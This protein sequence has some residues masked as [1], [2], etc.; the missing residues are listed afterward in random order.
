MEKISRLIVK[1]R[2]VI[3]AVSLALLFPSLLGYLGTRVNYDILTYLPGEIETMQGQDIL[4]DQFGTG[5]FSLY[6][7]EGMEE[8]DIVTLR[9]NIEKVDHVKKVLSYDSLMDIS[10]PMEML[11]DD[12]VSAFHNGDANLMFI[13]FDD[14]TSADGTMDAIEEIRKVSNEQCFLSGMSA[15]VVDTKNMAVK[16][17]PIYVGI[18]V[19]LATIV[20]SL[21]MD[22]FLIPI[23]FLLSIGFAI[24]YNMGSNIFLGEISFITQSL[25]AVLQ[26]GVT[27]DYSIF[28]WH[29]YQ[30]ELEH[31]EDR[32]DAMAKAITATFQSVIGSSITTVAGFVALCFMSFTIGL[33]LGVVMAKGVV[34]GVVACVTVLP[35]MILIFDNLIEK[36]K[37]RPL[38]KEFTKIPALIARRYYV[39]GLIL[40]IFL[41]LA[42]IGYSRT[43]VYYDLAQTL[44][45]SLPSRQAAA[46]LDENFDMNSA[47]VILYDKNMDTS[48]TNQM[49]SS[50]KKVDGIDSVLG[51][52]SLVGPLLPKSFLPEKITEELE[53]DEYKMMLIS[54]EYAVAS[55]EINAQID[56][57]NTIVKSYDEEAMVVGEAPCTK[58]LITITDTDFKVVSWVSI[59]LVFVI[60]AIV[61]KS[62]SLPFILVAVIEFAIYINMGIPGY[63]G[64]TIPFIASVV[65]GT[66]QLGSTVDYAILMTT[67]YIKERVDGQSKLDATTTALQTSMKSIIVSALS[68]FSATFGVGLTSSIDMIGSLCFLMARGALISMVVVIFVLPSMYML[69]DGLIIRTTMGMKNC[70]HHGDGNRPHGKILKFIA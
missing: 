69:L 15:I 20:L 34:L 41:P 4:L 55:D 26:L 28:L 13:I 52:D 49:I 59:G 1:M 46:E 16:E 62:I 9:E 45:D 30:E 8:K 63:T 17:T 58:D 2:F 37:H 33:D 70:R 11:P 51:I 54:S 64:T 21:T 25:S 43:S 23:F 32:K 66:I 19:I 53:S 57:V 31:S 5:A 48:S 39:F 47:Y 36:T 56:E 67:R 40:L 44:P 10:V 61:L 18:A 22:S 24:A 6:V 3:F 12:I 50:L 14:T 60:I 27:L 29:S 65:I 42:L 68:F 35:S 38:L 7:V